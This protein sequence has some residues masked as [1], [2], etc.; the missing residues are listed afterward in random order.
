MA[1]NIKQDTKS[2]EKRKVRIGCSPQESGQNECTYA[3]EVARL[4][5]KLLTGE[6]VKVKSLSRV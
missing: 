3:N 1:L 4:R 2:L 6:E 5:E